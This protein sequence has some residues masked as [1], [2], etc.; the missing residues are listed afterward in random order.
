MNSAL[1]VGGVDRLEDHCGQERR[2][3]GAGEVDQQRPPAVAVDDPDRD[4][5]DHRDQERRDRPEEPHRQHPGTKAAESRSWA[6]YRAPSS[7]A[8]RAQNVN[9]PA[10]GLTRGAQGD[11]VTPTTPTHNTAA[12]TLVASAGRARG[13]AAV[14]AWTLQPPGHRTRK[15]VQKKGLASGRLDTWTGLPS[16]GGSLDRTCWN[17][18]TS[19]SNCT[20][21]PAKPVQDL[22]ARRQRRVR[23]VPWRSSCAR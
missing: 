5:G 3:R 2:R 16:R 19:R 7:S 9:T 13:W 23:L 15:A 17:V 20:G 12:A 22:C 10:K 18:H 21:F 4:V 8:T 14:I 1:L 11:I 6:A